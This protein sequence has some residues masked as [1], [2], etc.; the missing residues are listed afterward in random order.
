M[1]NKRIFL[2]EKNPAKKVPLVVVDLGWLQAFYSTSKTSK[3]GMMLFS[4]NE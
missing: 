1:S 2:I 3:N 4:I